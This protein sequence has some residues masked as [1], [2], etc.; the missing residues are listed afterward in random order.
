MFAFI[1][2]YTGAQRKWPIR[3]PLPPIESRIFLLRGRKVFLGIAEQSAKALPLKM[4]VVGQNFG[5]TFPAHGF[6]GNTVREAVAFVREQQQPGLLLLSMIVALDRKGEKLWNYHGEQIP[7][8]AEL[9]KQLQRWA[10]DSKA[11]HGLRFPLPGA[12]RRPHGATAIG[13]I[14]PVTRSPRWSRAMRNAGGL[15]SRIATPS[16][17]FVRSSPGSRLR[18]TDS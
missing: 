16:G 7:R 4:P 18:R 14:A 5:Q 6:H 2:K 3:L 17:L 9:R 1:R 11:E 8:S 15:R 12:G 10:D 13:W